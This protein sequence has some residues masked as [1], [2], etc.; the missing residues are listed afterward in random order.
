MAFAARARSISLA[1]ALAVLPGAREARAGALE[2][3]GIVLGRG[4]VMLSQPS[5]LEH[6]WGRLTEGADAPGDTSAH[7]RGQAHLGLDW[8]PGEL[9]LVHAHGLA[10][11]E[12]DR[13]G[14]E[15]LGLTEAFLQFRPELTPS[16]TLR[17]RGG[18]FFPP[19][20]RENV[21]PLWSS[22][23]TITYS[24]WNSWIGEE[25]RLLGLEAA[26][27]RRFGRHEVQLAGS[28][29]VGADTLGTLIAWRGW[30]LG[31]R[32]AVV[33]E[34]VPLPNLPSMGPSGPFRSQRRDGT[35][36]IDEL[37]DRLGW[38]VRARWRRGDGLVQG[39]YLD[40]R[41]D[42]ELYRDQYSW[43]AWFAHAG[44]ELPLGSKVR[45]VS[46]GGLGESG[47]G[48][49]AVDVRF[50]AAY[51]LLT[52]GGEKARLSGRLDV[53]RNE[54][55]HRHFE[56]YDEEGHALTLAAFWTPSPRWRVGAEVLEVRGERPAARAS[57]ADPDVDARRATVEVRLSF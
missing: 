47:M 15:R 38:M 24:A 6:G 5:W 48:P 53:F 25:L 18:L 14:G 7:A 16:T 56:P 8:K 26:L 42:R 51:A 9:W 20:S 21:G 43:D 52:W 50:K 1:A 30:G 10:R 27:D 11:A 17:F 3:D 31:D 45:L 32:L 23:Y 37:D 33:G 34:V 41:G 54:D 40:N 22:P 46:E 49:G 39:S 2:V 36:P 35:R 55:L 29:F 44:F 4:L 28:A 19:I 13:A 57:G 12:P